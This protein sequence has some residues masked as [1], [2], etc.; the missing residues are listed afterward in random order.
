MSQWNFR[1]S[2]VKREQYKPED[3]EETA[4]NRNNS[5]AAYFVQQQY[6][7]QEGHWSLQSAEKPHLL[8]TPCMCGIHAQNTDSSLQGIRYAGLS[9][10]FQV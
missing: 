2:R 7:L 6:M 3:R 1:T 10:I 5:W 4:Y 9:R 8:L